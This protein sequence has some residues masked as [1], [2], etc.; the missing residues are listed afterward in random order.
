[1]ILILSRKILLKQDKNGIIKGFLLG[2]LFI[3][4]II[5]I[6]LITKTSLFN[7]DIIKYIIYVI[8][9]TIGGIMGV[10]KN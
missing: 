3:S 2:I 4:I 6:K 1:M 10:N 5:L 7:T 9:S 8:F